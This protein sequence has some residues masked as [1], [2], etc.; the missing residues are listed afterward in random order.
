MYFIK[1]IFFYCSQSIYISMILLYFSRLKNPG[2]ILQ[3]IIPMQLLN[4]VFNLHQSLFFSSQVTGYFHSDIAYGYFGGFSMIP[5]LNPYSSVGCFSFLY[6][7][8]FKKQITKR[9][10][11]LR[12]YSEQKVKTFLSFCFVVVFLKRA[13][14]FYVAFLP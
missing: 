8:L 4:F 12:T 13:F 10:S 2:M 14:L 1:N 11:F 6:S 9:V 3:K 5:S 7:L